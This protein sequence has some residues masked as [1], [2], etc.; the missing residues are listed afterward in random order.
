MEED[1]CLYQGL[2]IYRNGDIERKFKRL[3]WKKVLN[4]S[5]KGDGYNVINVKGKCRLRHRVIVAAFNDNFNIN[6]PTHL[7]DHIDG[8]RLNNAYENLRVVSHQSNTFN[9]NAKGYSWFQPSR[10]WKATIRKDGVDK[11]LGLHE[12]EEAARAAYLEAK[13]ELH[14]IEPIC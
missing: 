10:K 5:N 12:T 7:I 8:V 3:G 6:I 1:Y 13:A 4:T 9:S 2:R 14:V 11:Y